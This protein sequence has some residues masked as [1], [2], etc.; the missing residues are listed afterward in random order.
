MGIQKTGPERRKLLRIQEEDVLVC[1]P[2]DASV[3]RGGSGK[4]RHVVTKDLSQGGLLFESRE[5]FE[6]GTILKL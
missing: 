1:E 6:I 5:S 4:Q 2:F 3:L